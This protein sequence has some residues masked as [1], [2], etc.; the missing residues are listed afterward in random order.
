MVHP[1]VKFIWKTDKTRDYFS[2]AVKAGAKII[3]GFA[4]RDWGDNVAY[5]IDPDGHIIALAEKAKS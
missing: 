5:V 4:L 1:D 3:S 2:R